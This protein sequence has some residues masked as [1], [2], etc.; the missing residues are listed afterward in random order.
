LLKL[1]FSERLAALVKSHVVAKRYLT[2]KYPEYYD[3][4]SEASKTTLAFQGGVMSKEEAEAFEANPDAELII[5]MRTWDD[6]AKEMDIPVNNIEHL[7]AMALK[8]LSAGAL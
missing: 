7:K 1:G 5:R 8:H 4:L 6:L 2:Y 3:K